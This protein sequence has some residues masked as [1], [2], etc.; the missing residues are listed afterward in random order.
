V[1]VISIE[2][3]SLKV[4]ALKADKIRDA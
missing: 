3:L 1:K 4:A 2:G